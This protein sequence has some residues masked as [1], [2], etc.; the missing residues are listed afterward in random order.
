MS[1]AD[2]LF[3][4]ATCGSFAS[5]DAGIDWIWQ[6][7]LA[8][9]A[10][11]LLTSQ[12]KSGKTTLLSVLLSKIATGGE[13]A[14]LGVAKSRAVVVSEE[15]IENWQRRH[16]RLTF[17]DDLVFLCR[18]FSARPTRETWLALV[19]RLARLGEERGI[20]LVVIDPL[21]QFLPGPVENNSSAI[22]DALQPFERLTAA[23]Q[24]LLL[25]H[26]PRKGD[27]APGQAA[28]GSGALCTNVDVLVEMKLP[29][30]SNPYDRRRKLLAWSRHDQTP[31]ERVIELSADGRDYRESQFD[32]PEERAAEYLEIVRQLL[33]SPPRQLTRQ[34]LLAAWPADLQPPHAMMLWKALDRALK[35]GALGQEGAGR[36]GDPFRYF[37]PDHEATSNPDVDEILG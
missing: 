19:D 31:R 37:V 6:G 23:G 14:G 2:F 25:L 7:Y 17:G 3:Q 1:R 9:G 28:R 20:E 22:L 34:Q 35:R 18:P 15:R 32:E 8:R 30:A 27:T 33:T 26:H 36:K 4:E 10:T 12:W 29:P 13:L 5:A 11:T 24:C 16:Q 21:A